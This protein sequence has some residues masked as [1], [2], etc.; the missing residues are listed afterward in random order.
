MLEG[1]QIP[2][3]TLPKS[4]A[5]D[6]RNEDLLGAVSHGSRASYY[7][8]DSAATRQYIESRYLNG[9]SIENWI[10]LMNGPSSRLSKAKLVN[11]TGDSKKVSVRTFRCFLVNSCEPIEMQ[12]NGTQ[13]TLSPVALYARAD[14]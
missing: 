14:S 8:I 12:V 5:M 2:S 13:F 3:S 10:D 7:L 6:L 1:E 9:N 11:E 4:V